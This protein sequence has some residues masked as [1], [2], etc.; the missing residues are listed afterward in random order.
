MQTV[1]RCSDH[2]W[3]EARQ[4]LQNT[5]QHWQEFFRGQNVKKNIISSWNRAKKVE[6]AYLNWNLSPSDVASSAWW[7]ITHW[8]TLCHYRLKGKIVTDGLVNIA[9]CCMCDTPL[10]FLILL[11]TRSKPA[12]PVRS[13]RNV[14]W[15]AYLQVI[16]INY[17][18]FVCLISNNL[19]NS[20]I[21]L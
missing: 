10:R 4:P 16:T 9:S 13:E 12:K 14:V 20:S 3:G 5:L 19:D 6:F 11:L 2:L 17:R 1:C 15:V 8:E 7:H 18:K 21:S